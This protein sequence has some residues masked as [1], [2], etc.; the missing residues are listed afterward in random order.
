MPSPPSQQFSFHSSL[1]FAW[2]WRKLLIIC[3]W[4][5]KNRSYRPWQ[6]NFLPQTQRHINTLSSFT[7]KIKKSWMICFSWLL[8]PSPLMICASS[9]GP[10]WG[11]GE[12][13]E[14][15]VWLQSSMVLNKGLCYLFTIILAGYQPIVELA[16][17]YH[18]GANLGEKLS[19]LLGNLF[20][21]YLAKG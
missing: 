21:G 18:L 17:Y 6:A 9:L 16:W 8:F 13:V 1:Q 12:K 2:H 20:L 14:D 10:W 3:D 7:A 5:C 11:S 19:K 4:I 15:F